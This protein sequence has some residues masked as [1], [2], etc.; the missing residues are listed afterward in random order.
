VHLLRADIVDGDDENGLI[1]L[2]QALELVE[3]AGLVLAAPHIFLFVKVGC[4]RATG[5][6]PGGGLVGWLMQKKRF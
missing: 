3:V 5:V 2:Q 4:L 6:F 1:I